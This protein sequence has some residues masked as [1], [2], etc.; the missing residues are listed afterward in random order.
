[1]DMV[2]P[3]LFADVPRPKEIENSNDKFH[4]KHYYI[5]DKNKKN[6]RNCAHVRNG[7]TV[8]TR[9]FIFPVLE[10]SQTFSFLTRCHFAV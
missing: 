3:E 5:L 8:H 7:T 1:M 4:S 6:T 9:Q 2:P 10:Q